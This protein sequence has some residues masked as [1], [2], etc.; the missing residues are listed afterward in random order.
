MRASLLL[1]IASLAATAGAQSYQP[2]RHT[3]PAPVFAVLMSMQP[4]MAAVAGL[5]VLGQRLDLH[6]WIGIAIVVGANALGVA[7]RNR[8]ARRSAR[9]LVCNRESR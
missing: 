3:L 4:V 2:V 5:L 6:E 9:G 8:P 7:A 1:V